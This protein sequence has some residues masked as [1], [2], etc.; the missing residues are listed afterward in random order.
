[1]AGFLCIEKRMTPRGLPLFYFLCRKKEKEAL[2]FLIKRPFLQQMWTS[3]Y[4][5]IRSRV[6]FR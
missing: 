4:P 3:I 5:D 1:M 6:R 2:F